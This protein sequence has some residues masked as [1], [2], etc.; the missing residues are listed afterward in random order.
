MLKKNEESYAYPRRLVVFLACCIVF[1]G[2]TGMAPR[3]KDKGNPITADPELI[4]KITSKGWLENHCNVGFVSMK[5]KDYQDCVLVDAALLK[6]FNPERADFFGKDYDPEK[7]YHCRVKSSRGDMSCL[8][9]KLV[10]DEPDPVWPY[11]DAPPIQWPEPPEEQVYYPGIS[12]E[13]YFRG[14]C[15]A[16]AGKFIYRT[17]DN[18]EGVYQVRPQ[19][20]ERSLQMKDPYVMED[21]YGFSV[22]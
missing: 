5:K 7:Y 1:A 14:L 10:R 13:D 22:G 2:C 19:Y 20:P 15:K 6:P 17:V 18:V 21:P 8:Q 12:R 16:E 9:Y 3:P 4:Q 11:P